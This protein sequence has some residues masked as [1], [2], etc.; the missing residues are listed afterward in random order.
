MWQKGDNGKEVIFEEA[1]KYCKWVRMPL[2]D[3]K[4][5]VQY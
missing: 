1:Q 2:V 4:V 5:E 3:T